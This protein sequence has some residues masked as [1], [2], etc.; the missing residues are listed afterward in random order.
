MFHKSRYMIA[1][2]FAL[3]VLSAPA[4]AQTSD[5]A[6]DNQLRFT[7][8]LKLWLTNWETWNHP[9]E[10]E[11]A[12]T[13]A[14]WIP[15]L[16]VSY[17]RFFGTFGYF[18]KTSY[19]FPVAIGKVDRTEFD[20]NGG[21]WVLEGEGGRLG[22]TLGY[23]EVTQKFSAGF[24]EKIKAQTIGFT[25]SGHITGPW[26][27]YANGAYG[28]AKETGSPPAFSGKGYYASGE[29]GIA[30]ALARRTVLTAGYKGQVVDVGGDCSTFSGWVT[31]DARC[32]DTTDGFIIGISHTF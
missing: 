10:A 11:R 19:N 22:L 26:S 8:G 1:A 21:Y 28:P 5:A 32:R 23:K 7:V 20:L 30:Y 13:K 18:T 31:K 16:A 14:A 24:D 6:T 15:N 12:D 27:L 3:G 9:N 25:G 17:G 29:A 2:A 4:L